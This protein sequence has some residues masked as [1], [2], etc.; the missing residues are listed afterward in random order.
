MQHGFSSTQPASPAPTRR[1][2]PS[3]H[4][5]LLHQSRCLLGEPTASSPL[6]R[7]RVLTDVC[8]SL[9]MTKGT[10]YRSPN[11][12]LNRVMSGIIT[13][14]YFRKY[15]NNPTALEVG[16]MVAVLEI[17]AFGTSWFLLLFSSSSSRTM[18]SHCTGSRSCRRYHWKKGNTIQWSCCVHHWWRY[19]DMVNWLLPDDYRP[20]R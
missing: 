4:H 20:H 3:L 14:P 19:T 15:F 5:D 17:G 18:C 1:T 16:T 8:R 7:T 11:S 2:A 10:S 13:G 6:L 12:V 9:A